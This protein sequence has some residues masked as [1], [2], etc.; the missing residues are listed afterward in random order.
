[1]DL[2]FGI[3]WSTRRVGGDGGGATAGFVS[4]ARKVWTLAGALWETCEGLAITKC[5]T[6]AGCLTA[7]YVSWEVGIISLFYRA[8]FY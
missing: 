8:Q 5:R 6:A 4:Q 1:M 3:D 7:F 2:E